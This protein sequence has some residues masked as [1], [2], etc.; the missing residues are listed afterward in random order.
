M[1]PVFRSSAIAFIPS[2]SED[3]KK[4]KNNLT[5]TLKEYIRLSCD[6]SK[7]FT[8]QEPGKREQTFNEL[9]EL[10]EQGWNFAREWPLF[11]FLLE[12]TTP[13]QAIYISGG[14]HPF[15][16]SLIHPKLLEGSNWIIQGFIG[17]GDKYISC[18]PINV[19][20]AWCILGQM[21]PEIM[22]LFDQAE[23]VIRLSQP[24]GEDV[25]EIQCNIFSL[26]LSHTVSL[27]DVRQ[28]L[29]SDQKI[30]WAQQPCSAT[31]FTLN[32][33]T[34]C[35]MQPLET[36][37]N[38]FTDLESQLDENALFDRTLKHVLLFLIS[39][40][41]YCRA[42]EQ[43]KQAE[44]FKHLS[45]QINQ[46]GGVYDF[47]CDLMT[48]AKVQTEGTIAALLQSRIYPRKYNFKSYLALVEQHN[49]PRKTRVDTSDQAW[50]KHKAEALQVNPQA[51]LNAVPEKYPFED[52]V[53]RRLSCYIQFALNY[54]PITNRAFYLSDEPR[55]ICTMK[56]LESLYQELERGVDCAPVI[57]TCLEMVATKACEVPG[58]M[59]TPVFS[60][61]QGNIK[62][63]TYLEKMALGSFVPAPIFTPFAILCLQPM[64]VATQLSS[65]FNL[66]YQQQQFRL[67]A[68]NESDTYNLSH[69]NCMTFYMLSR[70]KEHPYN[71]EVFE[72]LKTR[73]ERIRLLAMPVYLYM[74]GTERWLNPVSEI[75]RR[76]N[77]GRLDLQPW[78]KEK[79]QILLEEQNK[80]DLMKVMGRLPLLEQGAL[81]SYDDG[82]KT[83]H[84]L[85]SGGVDVGFA[86]MTSMRLEAPSSEGLI[87]IGDSCWMNSVLQALARTSYF[88]HSAFE[89]SPDHKDLKSAFLE[90]FKHIKKSVDPYEMMSKLEHLRRQLY[91]S[92]FHGDFQWKGDDNIFY[93]RH[94]PAIFLGLLFDLFTMQVSYEHVF[95]GHAPAV[96]QFNKE[97]KFSLLQIPLEGNSLQEAVAK[98]FSHQSLGEVRRVGAV[99]YT[100]FT[101]TIRLREIPEQFVLQ[102]MRFKHDP[103]SGAVYLPNSLSF[104]SYEH[105]DL[106][107]YL[108]VGVKGSA[109]YE[110]EA[111]IHHHPR[112]LHFTTLVKEEGVWNRYDDSHPK[113]TLDGVESSTAYLLFF[114]KVNTGP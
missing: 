59:L 63:Q 107:P 26:F 14:A 64:D 46:R 23:I 21:T 85:E 19:L 90:V 55:V 49:P 97:D 1:E 53:F 68:Q 56:L 15:D 27:P 50:I 18:D 4:F 72:D 47:E 73:E 109:V 81:L 83:S 88:R 9:M 84:L 113:E 106:T 22:N 38:R 39:R 82:R 99:N 54:T 89:E 7:T 57:A 33:G 98:F 66:P 75:L 93:Q 108:A 67:Q 32:E 80:M 13:V 36:F 5:T 34:R 45:A 111:C 11:R 58:S 71:P 74:P 35:W 25:I 104:A 43:G 40:T 78:L 8:L 94:D 3:I 42:V 87:N 10:R 101:E 37:C 112:S 110:L 48:Q 69:L 52:R 114:K 70:D 76:A 62:I 96:Y 79:L 91:T 28:V 92:G 65:F 2:S 86:M 77:L 41:A 51:F 105:L 16:P 61:I 60:K 102:V 100:R 12:L 17:K 31:D 103:K 30:K 20:A 44:F 29:N 24:R 95:V 6:Y